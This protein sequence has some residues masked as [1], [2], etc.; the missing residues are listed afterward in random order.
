LRF[1]EE[2]RSMGEKC[3]FISSR[4]QTPATGSAHENYLEVD[5]DEA[6]PG[7]DL[8]SLFRHGF[9]VSYHWLSGH[10]TN[11][12]VIAAARGLARV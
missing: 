8:V 12:F 10:K 5:F 3:I 4:F 2:N 6:N 1:V 9:E 11:P 7:W